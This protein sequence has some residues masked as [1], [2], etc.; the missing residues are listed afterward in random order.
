MQDAVSG[1]PSQLDR[2]WWRQHA[3]EC[4]LVAAVLLIALALGMALISLPR[5]VR[6]STLTRPIFPAALATPAPS[7]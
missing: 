4:L 5:Q 1:Q 6:T 3:V 7:L 2:V